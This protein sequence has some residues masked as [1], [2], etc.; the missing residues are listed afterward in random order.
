[1]ENVQTKFDP[2][3]I[4]GLPHGTSMKLVRA[5]YKTLIRAY[6]PDV[7]R[8]DKELGE[9]RLKEFIEAYEFLKD[10]KRKL[11]FDSKITDDEEGHQSQTFNP[12]PDL[13]EFQNA[14]NVLREEWEFACD[15]HPEIQ[16]LY[17]KLKKI[18]R[19]TAL[20]FMALLVREKC[21]NKAEKI[22]SE[23]EKKF[24]VS[25]FGDDPILRKIAKH[26][27]L[28]GELAYAM[29]LNQAVRILGV[30]SKYR[31]LFKL[32]KDYPDF[33]TE[34]L[35]M[36]APSFYIKYINSNAEAREFWVISIFILVFAI[37]ILTD[38]I[39]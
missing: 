3:E 34:L 37:L 15:Y 12:K 38:F 4:L 30:N 5:A 33:G 23:L 18:D 17:L 22:S 28:Q 1:M 36:Y 29:Q 2:Y 31:I 24:L 27:I 20:A 9:L 32:A 25:K 35:K 16:E 14:T 11:A 8:G 26:A 39:F 10:F 7:Y 19:K 13:Y 21:Y 6:H